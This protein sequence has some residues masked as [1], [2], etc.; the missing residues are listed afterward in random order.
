MAQQTFVEA[1]RSKYCDDFESSAANDFVVDIVIF[2]PRPN[3]RS[4]KLTSLGLEDCDEDNGVVLNEPEFNYLTNVVLTN[5]Q[6]SKC[7]FPASSALDIC[8]NVV[9]LDLSNNFIDCWSEVLLLLDNLPK[10]EF[11]NL[12]SNR[13]RDKQRCLQSLKRYHGKLNAIVLN[14]TGVRWQE[15]VNL[16]HHLPVLRD[17]HLCL[18]NYHSINIE[19]HELASCFQGLECMRLNQNYF[20]Q[21]DEIAKLSGISSL[22]TLILSGNPLQNIVYNS[23]RKLQSPRRQTSTNSPKVI[24]QKHGLLFLLQEK[25]NMLNN[26][27][28]S[29]S[30]YG[31]AGSTFDEKDCEIG[32]LVDDLITK[33]AADFQE[34]LTHQWSSPETWTGE[35]T[36]PNHSLTLDKPTCLCQQTTDSR[37][38]P[39]TI[40]TESSTDSELNDGLSTDSTNHKQDEEEFEEATPPF[41]GLESLCMSETKISGWT[42]LDEVVKFPSLYS[43][44][45]RNVPLGS[46]F[47]SMEDRRKIIVAS[48][49]NIML[50]N[51]SEV[52]SDEHERSE[53]FYIRRFNDAANPP[54][55]YYKLIEKHGKVIP[56]K[57]LDLAKGFQQHATL[58]LMMDEKCIKTIEIQTKES[59]GKL[60]DICAATLKM[61]K[62]VMRLFHV[63]KNNQVVDEDDYEEL[64]L[65]SLPLSRYNMVDGDEIHIDIDFNI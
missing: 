10:L 29:D 46:E 62:N 12:S 4:A 31:S 45:I 14:N 56:P 26:A 41:Q 19:S 65:E 64:F 47:T 55:R 53:R 36:C 27:V 18:N 23:Q 37:Y 6:I 9:D 50:L 7:G 32:Q 15:V 20:K 25:D 42:D 38:L 24:E 21:W 54:S 63:S 22:K 34:S 44:K 39:N 13:L 59:V 33:C 57:D 43:F 61:P 51:G 40:F 35:Q 48:L 30:C 11:L 16:A 49:P 58:S 17:I 28:D 60:K 5:C 1:L 52:S 3:R 8:P 2:G